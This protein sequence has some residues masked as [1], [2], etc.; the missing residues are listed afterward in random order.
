MTHIVTMVTLILNKLA[1]IRVEFSMKD[2]VHQRSRR[3]TPE[4][5]VHLG[6]FAPLERQPTAAS[7]NRTGQDMLGAHVLAHVSYCS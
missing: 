3:S 4:Q 7:A 5:I 6:S 2:L 1:L